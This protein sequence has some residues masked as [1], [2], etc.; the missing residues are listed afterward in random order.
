MKG[1]EVQT[2]L[3]VGRLPVEWVLAIG[4]TPSVPLI[5]GNL[6]RYVEGLNDA[7]TL[8]ADF[9]SIP[10]VLCLNNGVGATRLDQ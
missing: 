10:L 7:R 3:R 8:L 5:P 1:R 4:G 6:L 2:A 9:F